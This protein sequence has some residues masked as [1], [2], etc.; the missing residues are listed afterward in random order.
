[1]GPQELGTGDDHLFRVNIGI[2]RRVP[3]Q[4]RIVIGVWFQGDD[5]SGRP[6]GADHAGGHAAIGSRIQH[7]IRGPV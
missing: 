2:G 5:E 3:L 6:Q 4:Q 1:M 7:V